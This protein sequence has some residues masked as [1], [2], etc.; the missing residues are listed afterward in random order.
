[1]QKTRNQKGPTARQLRVGEQVRHIL[2]P[3]LQRGSFHDPLLNGVL[4]SVSEVQMSPDLKIASCYVAPLGEYA[5]EPI[6]MALNRNARFIRGLVSQDLRQ[7]KYM[8][9][10]RFYLDTSFDN[11]AKIDALLRSPAV[12]RDLAAPEEDENNGAD[13]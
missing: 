3:I 9:Q 5:R 8:P 2:A 11:F 7:M 13:A 1:M 6:V 4:I 10:F 12:K